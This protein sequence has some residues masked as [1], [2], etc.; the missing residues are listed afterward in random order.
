MTA[1]F[2]AKSSLHKNGVF[3]RFYTSGL[4]FLF[5]NRKNL[6]TLAFGFQYSSLLIESLT[7]F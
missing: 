6:K 7:A 5:P 3:V 2:T 1:L 4:Y